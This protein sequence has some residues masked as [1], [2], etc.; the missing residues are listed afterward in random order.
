MRHGVVPDLY[1][2]LVR[3]SDTDRNMQ[4]RI[5]INNHGLRANLQTTASHVTACI[6]SIYSRRRQTESTPEPSEFT[7]ESTTKPDDINLLISDGCSRRQKYQDGSTAWNPMAQQLGKFRWRMSPMNVK[8]H[9]RTTSGT[10]RRRITPMTKSSN[11]ASRG[12]RAAI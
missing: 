6:F 3:F 4:H 12:E 7:A 5:C 10:H 1:A 8:N 2:R 11:L 9:R